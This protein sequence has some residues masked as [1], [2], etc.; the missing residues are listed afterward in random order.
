MIFKNDKMMKNNVC[1]VLVVTLFV[2]G[3]VF[4]ADKL[5]DGFKNP[6]MSA[7]PIARWCWDGNTPGEKEITNRLDTM[8]KAGFGGV[9]IDPGLNANAQLFKF[10][11]DAAKNRGMFVDLSLGSALGGGFVSPEEQARKITIGKKEFVGPTTAVIKVSDLVSVADSN[12]KLM[13]L[14]LIPTKLLK[15]VPGEDLIEKIRPDGTV[16]I[17]INDANTY[18]LYAGV[19]GLVTTKEGLPALNLLDKQAAEKYFNNVSARFTPATGGKL[20]NSIRSLVAPPFEPAA[21]NWTSDFAQQFKKRCDYDIATYL[22]VVLDNNLPKIR[23]RFYDIVRRTRYDFYAEL[24]GLYNERFVASFRDFCRNNDVTF[25]IPSGPVDILDSCSVPPDIYQGSA[26]TCSGCHAWDKLTSSFA[27]LAGKSLIIG[28]ATAGTEVNS[29]SLKKNNDRVFITGI[30]QL[31]ESCPPAGDS[32]L[33]RFKGQADRDAR[34]SYLFQNAGF[35]ARVAILCPAGDLW[36]DYGPVESKIV[37]G[38]WYLFPLWYALSQNG[39]TVDYLDEAIFPQVTYDD[40]KLHFGSRTYD[41][42]ILPDVFSL[43]FPTAR[44]LRFFAEKGGRVAFIGQPPMTGAGFRDLIR[45]GISIEVTMDH[46]SKHDPNRV[47]FILDPNKDKD[48]LSACTGDLMKTIGVSPTVIISPTSENLLFVHYLAEGRDIFYFVNTDADKPVSFQAQ[49][50]TADK[51]PWVWNPDS[52]VRKKFAYSGK[53]N[54]LKITIKPADSLV[55]VFEPDAK[56]K[57]ENKK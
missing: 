34:L 32:S 6:P 17:D 18:T 47:A 48:N 13:F 55:L 44:A 5:Y 2:T 45:R 16:A 31:I 4:S 23:T 38:I 27:H 9:E 20:G 10:A 26:P 52:G 7:R 11:V 41:A 22:P 25:R 14:R 12:D 46:F 19:Q 35:Q 51:I 21:E 54:E 50:D 3:T 30:T 56:A 42:I 57:A 39:Y 33:S 28:E 53:P 29:E 15:F 24:V 1:T 36:S 8:K 37:D 40:G 49:F 43:E